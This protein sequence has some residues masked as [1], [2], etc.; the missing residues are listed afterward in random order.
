MALHEL[1]ITAPIVNSEQQD[2]T[3]AIILNNYYEDARDEVL[4]AFDWNFAEKYRQ[5]TPIPIESPFPK[6]SYVYDYPND[7]LNARALYDAD[8]AGLSKEFKVSADESGKKIILANVYPAVLRYTRRI[9]NEIF[10][11]PEYSMALALYLAGLTGQGLTGSQQKADDAIKKY[12]DKIRLARITNASEGQ[13]VDDDDKT[14][15]D[16]RI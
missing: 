6:Y 13:E 10:F 15:L 2:D 3:R 12:W 1:G 9:S 16:E 5:I 14:Y 11:D 4:K 7:C 8:F